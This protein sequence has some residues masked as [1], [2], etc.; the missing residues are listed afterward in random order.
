MAQ[1]CKTCNGMG[2]GYADDRGFVANDTG[3]PDCNAGN[4]GKAP[5]LAK[6]AA[7]VTPGIEYVDGPGAG[8]GEA[9]D[10]GV[11][12]TGPE[13]VSIEAGQAMTENE[14]G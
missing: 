10:P 7:A 11:V 5:G 14:G 3:C 6:P 9:Y 12:N 1:A 2:F 13:T 4:P 8:G